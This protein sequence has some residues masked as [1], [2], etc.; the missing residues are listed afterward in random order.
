MVQNGFVQRHV[1]FHRVWPEAVRKHDRIHYIAGSFD[2]LVQLPQPASR[3]AELDV[4]DPH[5]K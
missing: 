5:S 2:A 1:P 4:S 3:G